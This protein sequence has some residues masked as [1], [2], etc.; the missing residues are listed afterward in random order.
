MADPFAGVASPI[1]PFAGV[2]SPVPTGFL[3]RVAD[4]YQ[5]RV[6]LSAGVQAQRKAGNMSGTS[7]FIQ[8]F[9]QGGGL[10]NDVVMDAGKAVND[11]VPETVKDALVPGRGLL[12]QPYVQ[13]QMDAMKNASSDE[14]SLYDRL[15][16]KYPVTAADA[17]GL[18]NIASGV[19]TLTGLAKAAPS[20]MKTGKDLYQSGKEAFD[21]R[22][23]AGIQDVVLPK[24]TAGEIADTA[25]QRTNSGGLF[26]KQVYTPNPNEAEM[27]QTAKS[28]GI[29]PSATLETN[30]QTANRFKN[31]EAQNLKMELDK[32]NVPIQPNTLNQA[33][34]E[35][36]QK[37]AAN[38]L[39]DE[40]SATI[41]KIL[42][43]GQDAIDKNPKT[44]AG[45]LQAR[46]DFDAAITKFQPSALDNEAPATAFRA[47]AKEVRLGLND[48]VK[49]AVPDAKV[50]ASL[51]KQ[52]HMYDAIDNMAGKLSEQPNGRF[53]RFFAT[54]GGKALKYG[55]YAT[56]ATAAGRAG[57]HAVTPKISNSYSDSGD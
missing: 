32:A 51:A 26:N 16:A 28:A 12:N 41:R 27:I 56:G 11:V 38:P 8:Q 37:I 29:K 21:A 7:S 31:T 52:S 9:G 34:T 49:T 46:K 20:T 13:R 2:A 57:L 15:Q 44:A 23:L 36:A 40:N 17:E 45:I 55:A 24:Q 30:I 39:V 14:P 53:P 19:A 33:G 54:K 25:L 6:D 42:Q 5:K 1:D 50:A 10:V 3:G 4:D 43:A 48:V 22:K 18:G 47:A 35:I